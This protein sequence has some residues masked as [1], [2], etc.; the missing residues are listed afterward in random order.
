MVGFLLVQSRSRRF[1]VKTA[2]MAEAL[3]RRMLFMPSGRVVWEDI[4]LAT[5]SVVPD[6]NKSG[7]F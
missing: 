1:G 4:W 3:E 2:D 7:D 5:L 6:G